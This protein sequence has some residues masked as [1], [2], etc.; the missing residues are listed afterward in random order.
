MYE[1]H[2]LVECP[3]YFPHRNADAILQH[4]IRGSHHPG[5][6]K[7]YRTW[8]FLAFEV[9]DRWH[10]WPPGSLIQRRELRPFACECNGSR[11]GDSLLVCVVAAKGASRRPPAYHHRALNPTTTTRCDLKNKVFFNLII[12][13]SFM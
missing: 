6:R 1:D 9:A 13:I 3:H 12:F 4:P 8:N 11:R 2:L 10:N 5:H 7:S